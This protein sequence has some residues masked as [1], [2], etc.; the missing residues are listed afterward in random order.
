MRRLRGL[1]TGPQEPVCTALEIGLRKA[2]AGDGHVEGP[3]SK[4]GV[5]RQGIG[6][7]GFRVENE[8]VRVQGF[9]AGFR[10]SGVGSRVLLLPAEQSSCG[11][12]SRQNCRARPFV[13]YRPCLLAFRAGVSQCSPPHPLPSA[14]SSSGPAKPVVVSSVQ[15]SAGR[16]GEPGEGRGGGGLGSGPFEADF[17][18]T[19][20]TAQ[21]GRR[22]M[23][24][25]EA[26]GQCTLR[27][28]SVSARS[29]S[30]RDGWA[31]ACPCRCRGGS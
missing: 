26:V 14:P 5:P 12:A 6:G 18:L 21:G 29:G 27:R 25:Q 13:G 22:S 4:T 16:P 28:P 3:D 9:G 17:R 8:G 23:N 7:L 15:S 11:Q 2:G 20:T 30:H 10:T 1:G 19:S 31:R 24:A